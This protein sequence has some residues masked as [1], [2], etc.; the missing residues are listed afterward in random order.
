[1]SGS[2]LEMKKARLEKYYRAEEM[3]LNA[4]SYELDSRTLTRADLGTVQNM[5]QKLEGEIA[6]I[7]SRG[8][9]KRRVRRVVPLV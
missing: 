2:I 1:M 6:A 5:I 4:Q 9:T 7:E 8:S 3:I